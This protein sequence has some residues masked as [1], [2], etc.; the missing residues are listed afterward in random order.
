MNF[1]IPYTLKLSIGLAFGYLLY[2]ALLRRL[3]FYNWNRFYLLG[4]SL[5]AFII[6]LID[7]SSLL[8]QSDLQHT[9]M[10][11]MIPQVDRYTLPAETINK[12]TAD[13][14]L[15][16]FAAVTLLMVSGMV[17]FAIRLLV[18]CLSFRKLLGNAKLIIEAPVKVYQV[19]AGI[20][21]FSFINSIF[22]NQHAHN[23]AEL[24]EIIRHELIHVRQ[25]HSA[26]MLFAE[27]LCLLNW[28]NP[29]AWLIRK[30]IRQNLEFIADEQ[31][32]KNGFDKKQYQYLL[33]KVIG[34]PQF[35]IATNFNFI[36]LKKRIAMM[37]K[38]KTA[39]VQLV[40]FLGIV[41]LLAI[42][43]LAF[44]HESTA[45]VKIQGKY[46]DTVPAIPQPPPPP[47]APPK[48][49]KN[50][51]SINIRNNEATVTL[52]D[53]T[54]EN[55]DL[56]NDA[57]KAA[58][59]KKYGKVPEPP[60]A[61]AA[62]AAPGEPPV[63][64]IAPEVAE[65]LA[66]SETSIKA[67]KESFKEFMRRNP[68]VKD[69]QWKDEDHL[70]VTLKNGTV[71][72]YDFSDEGDVKKA[73]S[74]YGTLPSAP[75]PPPP[76]PPVPPAPP[77]PPTSG[78]QL[79]EPETNVSV[80]R[81]VTIVKAMETSVN[82]KNVN[83]TVNHVQ[84]VNVD[85]KPLK[86]VSIISDVRLSEPVTAVTRS[87]NAPNIVT[88]VQLLS[89]VVAE[90]DQSFTKEMLEDLR[91]KLAEKGYKFKVDNTTYKN[92]KLESISASISD[93][94]TTSNFSVTGFKKIIILHSSDGWEEIIPDL[95]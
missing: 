50:V 75:P 41:P 82:A 54:K 83:T 90:I 1:L 91:L 17:V 21:P 52:K 71:E 60:V 37:N 88:D 44:R 14:Q 63:P 23:E 15:S 76:A 85:A 73:Q 77:T 68:K 72:K 35:S 20:P 28:Y 34:V 30:T 62:P 33:L 26:D 67:F 93:K 64:A 22:I 65:K 40:R 45:I 6:P 38:D 70:I 57:D 12:S 47:P 56:D 81:Q 32:L 78:V 11:N 89:E 80:N 13:A 25:K 48:L 10:I 51:K 84:S 61:P 55:Y 36:S 18:Q 66:K 94:K 46:Q 16:V 49:P 29:F 92:N 7:I 74:K 59:E 42:V 79:T 69:V 43:L 39:R 87:E 86:T 8:H 24:K 31:V 19:D 5:L 95:K 3:T 2:W 4:V 27:L 58:F 9:Q 53:G